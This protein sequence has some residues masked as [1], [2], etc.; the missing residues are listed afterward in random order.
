MPMGNLYLDLK[1]LMMSGAIARAI[2]PIVRLLRPVPIEFLIAS[3]G[4]QGRA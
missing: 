1:S 4:G 2:T 3:C